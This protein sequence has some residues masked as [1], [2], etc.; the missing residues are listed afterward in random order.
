MQ[1][2]GCS[3]DDC[4]ELGDVVA[5]EASR[6]FHVPRQPASTECCP[7]TGL[8]WR[9]CSCSWS[10]DSKRQWAGTWAPRASD[11]LKTNKGARQAQRGTNRAESEEGPRRV[12]KKTSA[13]AQVRPAS[14]QPSHFKMSGRACLSLLVSLFSA[15]FF[16]ALQSAVFGSPTASTP[17]RCVNFAELHEDGQVRPLVGCP[18]LHLFFVKLETSMSGTSPVR[19]VLFFC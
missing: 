1:V 7:A 11:G 15:P 9:S 13:L 2:V 3:S 18:Y 4:S 10:P 14:R 5:E 6:P 8:A 12:Q 17:F 16:S 19:Y